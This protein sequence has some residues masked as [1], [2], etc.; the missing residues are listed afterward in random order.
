M[1]RQN[2]IDR[3]YFENNRVLDNDIGPICTLE[4][5]AF[6]NQMQFDL[7]VK[8]HTR[9]RKLKVKTILISMLKKPRTDFAMNF[10]CHANNTPGHFLPIHRPLAHFVTLVRFETFVVHGT[11]PPHRQLQHPLKT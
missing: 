4:S 8:S 10:D 9:P 1:N 3:F 5:N 7:S 11:P 6:V 2:F